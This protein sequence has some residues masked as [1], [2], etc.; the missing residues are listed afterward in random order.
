MSVLDPARQWVPSDHEGARIWTVVLHNDREFIVVAEDMCWTHNDSVLAFNDDAYAWDPSAIWPIA[1]PHA[2]Y[3]FTSSRKVQLMGKVIRSGGGTKRSQAEKALQ[4]WQMEQNTKPA[5]MYGRVLQE[6]GSFAAGADGGLYVYER[7][8]YGPAEPFVD[9]VLQDL[10]GDTW[11]RHV[12]NET[13]AWLAGCSPGLEDQLHPDIIN[14]RNGLLVWS[15]GKWRLRP[16]DPDLRTT[17]QLPVA[18]NPD[19]ECPLYDEFLATS[20]PDEPTRDFLDEWSG[21][22]LTS[23]YSHQKALMLGGSSG[24]GKSQYLLVLG[25][26]VGSRNISAVNLQSLGDNRFAAAGLYGKLANIC[27][28]LSSHELSMTGIFKQ[29]TGGDVVRAEKKH[30]DA[31]EFNNLAKLSFSANEIPAT[32]DATSAFFDRWI[33]VRFPNK[34]R[35]TAA[36][37][38][39]IGRQ[40]ASNPDEMSGVLNRA[41]RGLS[42]LRR[43]GSFTTGRAMRRA[44]AEFRR[45]ADM[46]ALF[47]A[48]IAEGKPVLRLRRGRELYERYRAWCE[49][50]GHKTLTDKRLYSRLRD[51]T[52]TDDVSVVASESKG[53]EYFTVTMRGS[54]G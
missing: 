35:G 45:E 39:S 28:D 9:A 54:A 47:V 27:A 10:A 29:L 37:R 33:I 3:F 40:I 13:M 15:R 32:R 22:N 26:L 44:Q 42:R 43:Q 25:A 16:H 8:V 30:K 52:P 50:T 49:A 14:V 1:P 21:Y 46:V 23:D 18:F 11:S 34:F 38:K 4:A 31:F 17:I 20:Q 7:G 19:A 53:Y 5:A 6:K 48:D 2:V 51:W 24:S 41:L 12:R 36:E